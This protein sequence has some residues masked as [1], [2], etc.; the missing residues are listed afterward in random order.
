MDEE[1]TKMNGVN[2]RCGAVGHPA[3][4]IMIKEIRW[5]HA[6]Q[7]RKH[8]RINFFPWGGCGSKTQFPVKQKNS[9]ACVFW[10]DLHEAIEFP[11]SWR[12]LQDG[13]N[14]LMF[15]SQNMFVV[16]LPSDLLDYFQRFTNLAFFRNIGLI[17]AHKRKKCSCY[18]PNVIYCSE[19]WR[20]KQTQKQKRRFTIFPKVS[21]FWQYSSTGITF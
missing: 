20:T 1:I 15:N 18:K 16:M 13:P 8:R 7:A 2:P 19:I 4:P 12:G 14:S 17:P 6:D 5:P 9:S 21:L 3:N 11:W 10:L